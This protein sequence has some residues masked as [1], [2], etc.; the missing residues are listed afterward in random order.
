MSILGIGLNGLVGS[1]ICELLKD[2]YDFEV[3]SRSNGFDITNAQQVQKI[4]GSSKA[5]FV[6]HAAAKSNVDECER[7]KKEDQAILKLPKV[8]QEEAVRNRQTA[9]GI[10]V[11]GTQ[12][13]TD[14]CQKAGKK[15]IYISTDFVFDGDN[16]QT[17]PYKE[18]STPH[19]INWYGQTKYE[20]ER[21]VESCGMP[22]TIAR[23]AFPYR[24]SFHRTDFVRTF[25]VLLK[26]GEA[27]RAVTDQFFTPTFIDD[28]AY[29]LDVLI[30][31]DLI[32]IFHL[33]GNGWLTPFDA[34]ITIA[35][36]F[37]LNSNQIQETT[38]EDFFKNKALRPFFLGL[39]NDKI[40]QFISMKSFQEGVAKIKHQLEDI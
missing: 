7:D 21:I 20:G 35:D 15:L 29:G 9:W 22:F 3:F 24:A 16:D 8:A 36:V 30:Q 4:I 1:R 6:I 14:A 19:P 13:I 31:N 26:K 33:V 40:K 39:R 17:K 23:I 2:K 25:I 28:I 32:G 37:G 27:F 10:N 12:N 34:A 5:P 11:F 18:D 38:R